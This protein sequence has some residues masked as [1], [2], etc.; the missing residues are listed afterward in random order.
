MPSWS[1]SPLEA[2]VAVAIGSSLLAVAVPEFLADLRASRL[3]EPVDGLKRIGEGAL[4]YAAVH[5]VA[6]AF[7]GPV[8]LTP[9]E[10]PRARRLDDPPGA[11]GHPT[12]RAL[13]FSFDH[14]HAFGFAFD[15]SLGPGL[16]RFRA[17]AH[18]DLDGDGVVST[19]EIEGRADASGATLLPGMFVDREVE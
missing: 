11:W 6:E 5:G 1:P 2:L 18:G 19:F 3:A 17:T 16:S 9:A 12:W 10:I 15:S 14:P 13:G 7:P 8:A 4:A